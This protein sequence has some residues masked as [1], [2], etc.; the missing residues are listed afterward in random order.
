VACSGTA[1]LFTFFQEIII[2]TIIITRPIVIGGCNIQLVFAVF[3]LLTVSR[4]QRRVQNQTSH[5]ALGFQLFRRPKLLWRV[6]EIDLQV[7]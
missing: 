7:Q 2:I 4:D 1:L 5:D 6:K 3:G